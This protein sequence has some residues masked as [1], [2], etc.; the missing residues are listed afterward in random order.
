[1]ARHPIGRI[2]DPQEVARVAV[3]LASNEA[4]FVV[5]QAWAVDGGLTA[6]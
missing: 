3:F 5:G 6:A 2:G 4:S 1:M